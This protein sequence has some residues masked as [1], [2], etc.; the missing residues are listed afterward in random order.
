MAA[1]PSFRLVFVDSKLTGR[2]ALSRCVGPTEPDPGESVKARIGAE[3]IRDGEGEEVDQ[4][5]SGAAE[6]AFNIVDHALEQDE[7]LR[8]FYFTGA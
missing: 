8:Q 2:S 3:A 4:A 7:R 5:A 6:A 1:A